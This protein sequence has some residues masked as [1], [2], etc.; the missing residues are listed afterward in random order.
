MKLFI[1]IIFF[2]FSSN[3]L[4]SNLPQTVEE[5]QQRYLSSYQSKDLEGIYNLIDWR[6]VSRYKKK[7]VKVYTRNSLVKCF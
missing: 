3:L 5:L 1:A 7:M 6:G 4:A 2:T